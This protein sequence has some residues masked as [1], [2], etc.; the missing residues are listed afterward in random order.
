VAIDDGSGDQLPDR[1]ADVVPFRPSLAEQQRTH[2]AQAGDDKLPEPPPPPPAPPGILSR[3]WT[4]LR[5][6]FATAGQPAFTEPVDSPFLSGTARGVRD[7]I[8]K[9]AAWLAHVG[10]QGAETEAK[11]EADRKAFEQ[12]YGDSTEASLG[13]VAG[14]TLITAPIVGGVG[15]IATQGARLIPGAVGQ[16]AQFATA[17]TPAATTGGRAAQL[18]LQGAGTGATQAALTSGASDQSLPEQVA[19]GGITGAALGPVL[20][21]VT[22]AVDVLRGYAGGLRPEV[23]ALADKARQQGINVPMSRMSTNPFMRQVAGVGETLPFS[24]ADAM[25]LRNQRQFQA[26][27]QRQ[28]GGTGDTFGPAGM[29]AVLKPIQDGYQAALAKVPPIAGGK[30]LADDLANIGTDATQFL[31]PG[32][33]WHVGQAIRQTGDLFAGGPITPQAYRAFTGSDGAL[34]KLENAAPGAAQPYM[35]KIRDAIKDR[36]YDAAPPGVADDLKTLDQQYRAMKTF[37]PL[38][39]KST[40]GDISP[41]GL[42]QQVVNQ[43]NKYDSSNT[44]IAYT[45]GGEMGDLARIGKQFFGH[46]PDSGTP[47]RTQAYDFAGHPIATTLAAIPSLLGNRPLQSWLHSPTVSGRIIDTSLGGATPDI[48]RAIPYGLLGPLDYTRSQ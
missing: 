25:A 2:A 9:P 10:G 28:A 16:A 18:A 29:Q 11:N 48:G 31:D 17:A 35:A 41:P 3:A 37:Q 15:N 23:A 30:P 47:G 34:K 19:T 46:I 26:A 12:R 36:L 8:D 4:N 24:G 42:M 22:K 33:Q 32:Q 21:G 39:A 44:G 43:S 14:Q 1:P 13:R 20:G 27:L 5:D 45:G 40:L 7:V 38:V 6:Q